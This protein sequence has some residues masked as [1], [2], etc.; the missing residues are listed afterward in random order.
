MQRIL[1]VGSE[2]EI[3][4]LSNDLSFIEKR[5]I[6]NYVYAIVNPKKQLQL[7]S[8]IEIKDLIFKLNAIEVII[9]KNNTLSLILLKNFIHEILDQ[10]TNNSSLSTL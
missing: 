3:N 9:K 8:S 1:I 6:H 2:I 5:G 10:K 7:W 4:S